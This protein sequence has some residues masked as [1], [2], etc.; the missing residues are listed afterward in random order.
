VCFSGEKAWK[1][2]S[3]RVR[4][5]EIQDCHRKI[6]IHDAQDRI[7]PLVEKLK[8]MVTD[9]ELFIKQ[10]EKEHNERP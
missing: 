10:L 6:T 9:L 1:E 3:E 4:Y 5:V 8:L 7:P 2:D